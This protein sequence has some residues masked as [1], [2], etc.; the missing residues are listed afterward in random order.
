M[1]A[2]LLSYRVPT[3]FAPDDGTI[4]VTW[5]TFFEGLGTALVDIGAPIGGTSG[6]GEYE[7]FTTLLGGYSVIRADDLQHANELAAACPIL[8]DGGGVEI[9]ELTPLNES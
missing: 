7:Q 2:Y 4:G 3:D 5:Q 6:I 1:P 8:A 9:G